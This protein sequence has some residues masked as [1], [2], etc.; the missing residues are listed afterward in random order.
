M[1]SRRAPGGGTAPD[2][3]VASYRL[4]PMMDRVYARTIHGAA[5][6]NSQ[7]TK[8]VS[9]TIDRH[10]LVG[11]DV[12]ARDD[13]RIGEVKGVT[14]DAEFVIV[15]RALSSDLLVPMDELHESRGR[16]EIRRAKS[17]LDDAPEVDADDMTLEDR[18]RLERFYHPRAA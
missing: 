3:P 18:Q 16:L 9:M 7:H 2:I 6:G 13:V 4:E 8:E 5:R 10:I 11:R 15:D 17:Y 12:Y 1:K 14:A